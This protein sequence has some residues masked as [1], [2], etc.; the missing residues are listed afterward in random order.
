MEKVV[1]IGGGIAGL[2]CMNALLDQ[3]VSPLLLE[4]STIGT[5]KMCGEF[6]SPQAIHLLNRWNI[7][8][9]E[10]I[11]AADFSTDKKQ[12]TINF[13][14]PAGA[15]SR[16]QV[17]LSLA[18]RAQ[19]LGGQIREQAFI[20]KIIPATNTTPFYL[21]LA[22]GEVIQANTAIF[23]A[24]R[25]DQTASVP[26]LPYVGFKFH[27]EHIVKPATLLM[28]SLNNAYLGIV[29][30]SKNI[31]N[32]ACLL[33]SKALDND[34]STKNFLK[35][36]IESYTQL[37]TIFSKQDF[38]NIPWLETRAPQFK[39]KHLPAW[40]RAYWIG[41]A[42]AT[43]PPAIGSGFAH[44]L[45]SALIAAQCYLNNQQYHP[46]LKTKLL[47]GK[48]MHEIMLRP[49]IASRILPMLD[50]HPRFLHYFMNQLD[51]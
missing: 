15:I 29:P 50:Q 22:T 34:K 17:E 3:G 41:D 2:S 39:R 19:Q 26:L 28:Y 6:L 12:L 13:K 7:D 32:C 49:T 4:G 33:K 37:Q 20:T 18:K 35:Q 27:F 40:P 21:H 38:S 9:T 36:I 25:Y 51:Y 14:K 45:S 44:A 10:A 47:L 11:Y 24:G 48:V 42:L 46:K 8:T 5:E 16:S 1:I 31:S 43:L 30:I 23:A